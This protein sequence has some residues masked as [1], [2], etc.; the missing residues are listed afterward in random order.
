MTV[1]PPRLAA[2]PAPAAQP[3]LLDTAAQ[4]LVMDPAAPL[5]TVAA[6]AGVGRTTLH[7]RFPTR[8]ALLVAVAHRALDRCEAAVDSVTGTD[9]ADGGLHRLVG[10]LV[11]VGP[12]LAYLFRQP[13][14][15]TRPDVRAR[16]VDLDPRLLAVLDAA[17]AAGVLRRET[18][19]W[20][21]LSTLY[22]LVYI[23]WEGIAMGNL[24]PVDAPALV[25]DTMVGGLGPRPE[26]RR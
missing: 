10:A 11:P 16:F 5:A 18:R 26:P 1:H 13:G 17:K 6:A 24:A 4:V 2:V 8:D 22:A 20:W 25:I 21:C 15:E 9:D 3:D 19:D 23:A 12:Q 7:K 14:L